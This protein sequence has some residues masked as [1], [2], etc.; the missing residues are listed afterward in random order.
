VEVEV[1]R[2]SA[3]RQHE[4][5]LRASGGGSRVIS[6]CHP[7]EGPLKIELRYR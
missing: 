5:G 1:A 7:S 3:L 2:P 4:V 6:D